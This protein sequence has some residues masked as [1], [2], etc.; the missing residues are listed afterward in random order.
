MRVIIRLTIVFAWLMLNTN[1]LALAQDTPTP[2]PTE[3]PTLPPT[4]TD[5]LTAPP[6]PTPSETATEAATLTVAPSETP[7]GTETS[8]VTPTA[9]MT[10]SP[11]PS[12]TLSLQSFANFDIGIPQDWRTGPTWFVVPAPQGR[13]LQV[14]PDFEIGILN[15]TVQSDALVQ[16]RFITRNA[17]LVLHLRFT[18]SSGYEAHIRS[19]NR[20]E[21]YR[22]GALVQS[23]NVTLPANSWQAFQFSAIGDA[24]SLLVGSIEVLRVIDSEPLPAGV[25]GLRVE[26]TSRGGVALDDIAV[27]GAQASA[28]L[29]E[30]FL[31]AQPVVD[32]KPNYALLQTPYFVDQ[33]AFLQFDY[34]YFTFIPIYSILTGVPNG[35]SGYVGGGTDFDWSAD[36]EHILSNFNLT[37]YGRFNYAGGRTEWF[38]EV[39]WEPRCPAWSPDGNRVA[40][41]HYVGFPFPVNEGIYVL[42]VPAPTTGTQNLGSSNIAALPLADS[43]LKLSG[44]PAWSPDSTRIASSGYLDVNNDGVWNSSPMEEPAGIYVLDMAGNF[45]HVLTTNQGVEGIKW[46]PTAERLVYW[47]YEIDDRKSYFLDLN[48]PNAPVALTPA[49]ASDTDL[50]WSPDGQFVALAR[51]ITGQLSTSGIYI[52]P[53]SPTVN[54]AAAYRL[55]GTSAGDRGPAWS[56]DGQ[57]IALSGVRVSQIG[58]QVHVIRVSDGYTISIQKYG[59]SAGQPEWAVYPP[60]YGYTPPTATATLIT[61][62][63]LPPTPTVTATPEPIFSC[64]IVDPILY[65]TNREGEDK[66]YRA[67]NGTCARVNVNPVGA[68]GTPAVSRDGARIAFAR[69]A[70]SDSQIWAM[71]SNGTGEQQLTSGAGLKRNPVWSPDGTRLVY[72]VEEN[73]NPY[74]YIMNADGTNNR[75][76][77]FYVGSDPTW[78]PDGRWIAYENGTDISIV[79]ANCDGTANCYD[80][81]FT[82]FFDNQTGEVLRDPAWTRDGSALVFVH[83]EAPYHII[84]RAAVIEDAGNLYMGTA[85]A[86]R[87]GSDVHDLDYAPDRDEIVYHGKTDGETD[88]ELWILRIATQAVT[89]LTD[90]DKES[91]GGKWYQLQN[92]GGLCQVISNPSG[93]SSLNIRSGPDEAYPVVGSAVSGTV[94]SV[95]GRNSDSTWLFVK[96][97][98]PTN[99]SIAEFGWV[100]TS[101]TNTGS[102]PNLSAVPVVNE[103]GLTATPTF[104]PMPTPTA[105]PSQCTGYSIS[106]DYTN[107]R[108]TPPRLTMDDYGIILATFG[109]TSP[110]GIFTVRILGRMPFS[111]PSETWDDWYRIEFVLNGEAQIGWASAQVT[112][113]RPGYRH[114]NCANLPEYSWNVSGD[115]IVEVTSQSVNFPAFDISPA[116]VDI[117]AHDIDLR[118]PA[119][120][121]EL[122]VVFDAYSWMQGYGMN[123][124]A[125]RYAYIY[126]DTNH[127]HSGLD[128]GGQTTEDLTGGR[129]LRFEDQAENLHNCIP[130]RIICDGIITSHRASAG[131]GTG[132][133]FTVQCFAPEGSQSNIYITYNH[134][135]PVVLNENTAPSILPLGDVV[136]AGT[137][138]AIPVI[139]YGTPPNEA[140][141]HLHI[142][143]FF[144]QPNTID[145]IRIN[146][147]L[148]FSEQR[149]T[150]ML[151]IIQSYYPL[152]YIDDVTGLPAMFEWSPTDTI[153]PNPLPIFTN[154]SAYPGFTEAQS[155]QPG[156]QDMDLGIERGQL[157]VYTFVAD[158]IPPSPSSLQIWRRIDQGGL[159]NIEIPGPEY[160]PEEFIVLSISELITL[161]SS[162]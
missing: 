87:Y 131:A 33:L 34:N 149:V 11:T 122:P 4:A 78:S 63:P 103:Q 48:T 102:C 15:G 113:I 143:A 73:G 99:G 81:S 128:F 110:S 135:D 42:N 30:N 100:I 118:L 119:P 32:V 114:P 147:L 58:R 148:L 85:A 161:L 23:A 52:I 129:C 47:Q 154:F 45:S 17:A 61:P 94:L 40:Y 130:I 146:P 152:A 98:Q 115:T 90:D 3:T 105:D 156:F 29:P 24:V 60:G 157:T 106:L 74:L 18:G 123:E 160:I 20:V 101:G 109:P 19:D 38:Y 124:F 26:G 93:S 56:P 116:A 50:T 55:T 83:E 89:R 13:F 137:E 68:E 80:I 127:I 10:L 2:T 140:A 39:D 91:K 139:Q 141:P 36:G 8:T 92:L 14:L 107:I 112:T 158:Q 6:P 72:E 150:E 153:D 125:Y 108:S 25:A 104:T 142:E 62:T 144:G 126:D 41:L 77:N 159:Q 75:R 145:S 84:T 69:P 79:D 138:L 1:L 27:Y 65:V 64:G 21:L 117:Y 71:N 82:Y 9:V 22:N 59:I 95:F 67:A 133:G 31:R 12:V 51:D 111:T 155:Q 16:G 86:L 76:L 120:F 134:L 37:R 7:T 97:F 54:P 35:L 132:S 53:A 151:S 136:R 70:G 43:R 66:I 162:P 88:D 44:C 5:V 28:R 46:S 96:G 57:W 121:T 49:N